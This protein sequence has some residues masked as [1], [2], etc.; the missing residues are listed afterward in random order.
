MLTG[1]QAGRT[2]V[3][4]SHGDLSSEDF[5]DGCGCVGVSVGS[6]FLSSVVCVYVGEVGG[7]VLRRGGCC[8][9]VRL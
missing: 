8:K 1:R 7:W 9:Q 3:V 2:I 4:I 5:D 6:I